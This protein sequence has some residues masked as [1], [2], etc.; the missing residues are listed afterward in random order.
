MFVHLLNGYS[1]YSDDSAFEPIRRYLFERNR[2][3]PGASVLES[4][5]MFSQLI[6]K[7]RWDRAKGKANRFASHW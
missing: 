7:K 4:R 3:V 1:N 5:R 2:T 6:A